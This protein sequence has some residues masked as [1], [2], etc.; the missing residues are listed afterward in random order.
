M[1]HAMLQQVGLSPGEADVYLTCLRLG[2]Q[3]LGF[4]ARDVRLP[5]AEVKA[6]L[7]A[8]RQRGFVT[9]Y[10][11]GRK[12]FFTA[13]PPHAVERLLQ[14]GNAGSHS[15]L[16]TALRALEE[17][18]QPGHE[19]PDI[20]FYEGEQGLMAAYEDTLT[21]SSNIVAVASIDDTESILQNYMPAYYQRRRAVGISIRAIFPDTPKSRERRAQDQIELR[22]SRLLPTAF[23][24]GGIEWNAYDDKVAFFS[25]QEQI[26]VIIR[27]RLIADAMRSAFEVQWRVADLLEWERRSGK[28]Q[29]KGQKG[30]R[31]QKGQK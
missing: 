15:A 22:Q 14:K 13:E 23:M 26:A 8:L 10:M 17:H 1:P 3:E 24:P 25:I 7:R 4:I 21:A 19:R 9:R 27:S 2:T 20:A 6:I 16:R 18:M 5:A 30:Q 31:A 28:K 29:K 12:E 11:S